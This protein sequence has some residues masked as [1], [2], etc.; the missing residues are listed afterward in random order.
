MQTA[1]QEELIEASRIVRRQ[2]GRVGFARFVRNTHWWIAVF[3]IA[4]VLFLRTALGWRGGE[5]L[6]VVV[7]LLLWSIAGFWSA[8]GKRLSVHQLLFLLDRKGGWR[9]RFSSAWEFQRRE[10]PSSLEERHIESSSALIERALRG[11]PEELPAASMRWGWLGPMFALLFAVSPSFRPSLAPGEREL[12]AEMKEVAID[13]AEGLRKEAE[14]A[15]NF[16][17]L[18]EQ[19]RAELEEILAEV[20]GAADRLADPDGLT[21]GE[22]LEALEARA[23]AA[24]RLA[25]K[26][27]L[28]SDGW[29]SEELIAEMEKHPDTADLALA[30]RE[31]V[32]VAASEEAM[33]LYELLDEPDLAR[34]TIDR[35]SDTLERVMSASQK[36]D[37][38]KPVGERVG[39]ASRKLL[40]QQSRTAAR[41]FFEL[42]RHFQYLEEREEARERL[43]SLAE[44]V[45][46]TGSEVAGS[47]LQQMES[48]SR[49]SRGGTSEDGGLQPLEAGSMPEELQN[50][51]SP[52]MAQSNLEPSRS[53][54]DV[55]PSPQ[56]NS[57]QM[58]TAPVPG[59]EAPQSG[60]EQ[61]GSS[62]L[63]A[64]IP[65]EEPAGE[66]GEQG[67]AL[68][69]EA[70]EGEGEGGML[71]AP[72][73][74]M[75]SGDAK[76]G[77]AG[78]AQS[79]GSG[80][81]GQ[82][83]DQAGSGTAEL[84]ENETD[85]INASEDSEVEAQINEDGESTVRAV[86]GGTRRENANRS[87]QEIV[88]DF[89]AAEEQALDGE[90]IPQSRRDHIIRYFSSIRKQF[91]E[92]GSPSQ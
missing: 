87:R 61:G 39:N 68:S 23:R 74:G 26:L 3:G 37:Q 52:Q 13:E 12:T 17:S 86:E 25:E 80:A 40:E 85:R 90:A 48:L 41:E 76:A 84:V 16:E 14:R 75:E 89:L 65:G 66:G 57:S 36:E 71:S 70:N 82:G 47:E 91:E 35:V 30:I 18:D 38:S 7:V 33:S 9:D 64:P 62:T 63:Q 27:G 42:A 43:E 20:E 4:L 44:A 8:F 1:I 60:N 32:A 21:S 92:Q 56:S 45:R 49:E 79:G 67:M 50:L 5:W 24:E 10:T 73:P 53:G 2:V 55:A 15:R 54:G 11:L 6:P 69:D 34:D 51:V 28:T 78:F 81:N 88:R 29:A 31:K 72:I 77:S 46:E 59:E 83:G 22:M 58:M 19:E